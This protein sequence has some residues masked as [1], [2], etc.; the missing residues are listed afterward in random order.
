LIYPPLRTAGH[1]EFT[2]LDTPIER[3]KQARVKRGKNKDEKAPQ[4]KES[5]LPR[6]TPTP[7]LPQDNRWRE[8]AALERHKQMRRAAYKPPRSTGRI[9]AL[10][11]LD[12]DEQRT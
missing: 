7:T 11:D 12:G 6:S 2:S 3:H 8:S 4:R 9:G 1:A 5:A 10:P